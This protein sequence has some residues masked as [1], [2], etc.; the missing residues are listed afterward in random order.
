MCKSVN[1]QVYLSVHRCIANVREYL[2]AQRCENERGCQEKVGGGERDMCTA[3]VLQASV[4]FSSAIYQNRFRLHTLLPDSAGQRGQW[5]R[6]RKLPLSVR[7]QKTT[8]YTWKKKKTFWPFFFVFAPLWLQPFLW[9]T[10]MP[11][12]EQVFL[13]DGRFGSDRP[14]Y[15]DPN[16]RGYVGLQ[17]HLALWLHSAKSV[18]LQQISP[19]STARGYYIQSLVWQICFHLNYALPDLPPPLHTPSTLPCLP[20]WSVCV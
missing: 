20:I 6:H 11:T 7:L 13:S 8:V 1:A 9:H 15:I 4:C 12:Q 16:Q 3:S 14:D 5:R 19:E 2:H 10:C 17:L 18:W